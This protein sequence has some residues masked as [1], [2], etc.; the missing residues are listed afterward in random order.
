MQP[1]DARQLIDEGSSARV[2]AL[3]TGRVLKLFHAGLEPTLARRE[4]AAAG[5]AHASGLNVAEPIKLIEMGGRAGVVFERIAGRTVFAHILRNPFTMWPLVARMVACQRV[6]HAVTA[7]AVL[8]PVHDLIRHRLA[9]SRADAGLIAIASNLLAGLPTDNRLGHGDFHPGNV[10]VTDRELVAIDW[11]K[12][13]RGP[14]AADIARSDLLIRYGID[15]T[16]RG[17]AVPAVARQISA[18]WYR[19]LHRQA[20]SAPVR[21]IEAWRIVLAIAWLEQADEKSRR[22]LLRAI[23]RWNRRLNVHQLKNGM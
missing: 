9:H 2:F 4:F 12:A 10:I 16:R 21:Q 23:H 13:W 8:P 11:G 22:Q 17:V 20:R 14:P 18:F 7:S 6:I 1:G 5:V 3:R 19:L 15:R